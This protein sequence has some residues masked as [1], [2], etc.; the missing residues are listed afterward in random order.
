MGTA[1]TTLTAVLYATSCPAG[2]YRAEYFPNRTLSGRAATILCV[3]APLTRY[4]RDGAPAGMGVAADNFSARWRGTFTFAGGNR[5]FLAT[6]NNGMEVWL[7]S[8]RILNRWNVSGTVSTTRAVS[9][10]TH[11]VGIRY[12]EGTGEATA[13]LTW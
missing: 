13:R 3:P 12:W 7:D 9:A 4:W 1:A 10:G 5:T 8:T 11:S 6:H 2:R